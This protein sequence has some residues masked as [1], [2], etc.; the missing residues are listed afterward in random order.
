MIIVVP[1]HMA[2]RYWPKVD[3]PG[4]DVG[5]ARCRRRRTGRP[6][7]ATDDVHPASTGTH[8]PADGISLLPGRCAW[9]Q[10]RTVRSECRNMGWLSAGR[11]R[12]LGRGGFGI[13]PVRGIGPFGACSDW[14]RALSR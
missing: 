10:R 7:P 9:E 14:G 13:R 12:N 3:R 11:Y 1:L 5:P 4:A 6:P 2:Q 8:G